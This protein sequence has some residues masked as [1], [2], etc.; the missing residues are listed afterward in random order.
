MLLI[1]DKLF[2]F[3]QKVENII[4]TIYIYIAVIFILIITERNVHISLKKNTT[5]SNQKKATTTKMKQW[6]KDL[7][8]GPTNPRNNGN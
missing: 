6:R 1:T 7:T 2:I 8:K 3:I 4:Y 5:D